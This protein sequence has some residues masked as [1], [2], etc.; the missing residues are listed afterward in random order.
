M[1]TD[2]LGAVGCPHCAGIGWIPQRSDLTRLEPC[3]C[4][5]TTRPQQHREVTAMTDPAPPADRKAEEPKHPKGALRDLMAAAVA[6]KVGTPARLLLAAM[7]A[8]SGVHGEWET[9]SLATLADDVG[10]DY[11][12]AKRYRAELVTVG[13]AELRPERDQRNAI[14]WRIL[15][16]PALSTVGAESPPPALSTGGGIAPTVGAE[17]P[18][19]RGG[20]APTVGAESPPL[21]PSRLSLD[22]S[23]GAPPATAAT[24]AGATDPALATQPGLPGVDDLAGNRAA[25]RRRQRA[26]LAEATEQGRQLR[27]QAKR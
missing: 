1:P 3:P 14:P 15:P 22:P 12:H 7:W 9:W 8:R 17:S 26:L 6:A 16:V 24:A 23:L 20:I 5:T 18:P 19:S 25:R 11:R 27:G 4:R 10:L 13:L 2:P 21:V